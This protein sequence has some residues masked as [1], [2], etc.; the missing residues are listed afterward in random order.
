[1]RL[2]VAELRDPLAGVQDGCVVTTAK[3]ITDLGNA[4]TRQLLGQ[5]YGH[6]ARARRGAA[7]AV[8]E[9]VRHPHMV[10]VRNG[11]LDVFDYFYWPGKTT[12]GIS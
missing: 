1:M 11:L 9:Q 3:R 7:A 4:M 5:G 10:M 12:G 6:L 2:G 8:G